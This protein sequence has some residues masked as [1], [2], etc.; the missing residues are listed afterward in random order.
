MLRKPPSARH[1]IPAYLDTP[2]GIVTATGVRF[3]TTRALL[4]EFAGGVLD[5]VPLDVLVSRAE[6]WLRS[7]QT[8]ALWLLPVLLLVLP[9]V[10]AAVLT[11]GTYLAWEVF[12]P[13][14]A[15]RHLAGVFRIAERPIVQAV[16]YVA[17][18]SVFGIRGELGAVGVG[19][20]G[21][22]ALRWQLVALLVR[23]VTRIAHRRLYSLPAPDQI[24]RA[25][26]LQAAIQHGVALPQIDELRSRWPWGRRR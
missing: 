15:N 11:L 19:L 4:E 24:L 5:R 20:A 26:V 12:S 18:L 13:V 2:A 6:V 25:F 21:F 9:P 22:M 1:D 16:L 23:P 7:G 10:W 14:M 3:S 17:V 8:V